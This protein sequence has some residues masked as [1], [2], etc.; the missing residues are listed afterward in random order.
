MATYKVI[1]V[2]QQGKFFDENSYDD[3][4]SYIARSANP[5]FTGGTGV[6]S[7]YSAATEMAQTAMRFGKD[8]GKKLESP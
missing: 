2:G 7:I 8:S 6:T 3:A 1:G 5:A 4:I